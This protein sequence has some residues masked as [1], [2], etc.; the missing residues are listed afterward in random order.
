MSRPIL[1]GANT[2]AHLCLPALLFLGCHSSPATD[3]DAG[4]GCVVPG[5]TLVA[6]IGLSP[7]RKEDLV[8]V[9]DN[10]PS[11][12]P[13]REKFM[14]QLPRLLDAL[15][16]P[17]DGSLPNL[18]VAILD[19]DMGSSGAISTGA[20]GAKNGTTLGDAGQ[21]QIVGGLTCGMT[22][23]NAR[24]LQ[25]LTLSPANYSGDIVQVFSCLAGGLGQAGCEYQQPLQALATA[26]TPGS[27]SLSE[28][29]R[30]EA[31][32]DLVI[33]SDQD[34]CSAFPNTGMFA[35]GVPTE[36]TGLRCA[37]RGHA[38]GGANLDYPTTASYA[39]PFNDCSSRTD[40]CPF[41]TDT[42]QPTGCAPLA[43]VHALAEQVKALKPGHSDETIMVTAISGWPRA[44]ANMPSAEYKIAPI[45]NPGHLTDAS[46]PATIYDL[47]PVCY[48]ADHPPIN[49][50]PTTGFDAEAAG[51]GATP[52]LR[53]SAFVDEFGPNGLKFSMCEADWTDA[54]KLF[55]GSV[56]KTLKNLCLDQKIVDADL[57][58]PEIDPDCIM[59]YDVPNVENVST[60][61]DCTICAGSACTDNLDSG[62][63]WTRTYLPLCDPNS[64]VPPC[65]ELTQDWTR[66]PVN[67]QFINVH[68]TPASYTPGGARY[69]FQ[70]RVCP[71]AD[72][73]TATLP[74]C[75]V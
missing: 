21:L 28:F 44:D 24:W 52:S 26:A 45:S 4:D 62:S 48:D 20:C 11:M 36:T 37:T 42:S 53:L 66:C 72:A 2:F 56:A 27:A 25:M 75:N 64:P 73:G 46:A 17:G 14:K 38:C 59:E 55:G 49:P 6:S 69:R 18:R 8:F 5:Y 29:V 39:H 57:S 41:S 60:P 13:K 19:G 9:I 1:P 33:I 70:C 51:Y 12:A 23:P 67:G 16:D 3:Q 10:S 47:W 65:W 32:L 31:Y 34:D 50:D 22:D 40:V 68:R 54:M 15:K 74:G 30:P 63:Q 61:L 71:T 58:T 43:D 35:P 7:V